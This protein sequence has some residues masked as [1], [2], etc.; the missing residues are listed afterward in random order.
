[1]GLASGQRVDSLHLV[2]V[3][4]DRVLRAPGVV[5]LDRE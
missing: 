4:T 3:L 1:M 2:D 5:A